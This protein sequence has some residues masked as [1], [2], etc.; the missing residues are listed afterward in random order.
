MFRTLWYTTGQM[1]RENFRWVGVLERREFGREGKGM[2]LAFTQLDDYVLRIP[3]FG[4]E[5]FWNGGGYVVDKRVLFFFLRWDRGS[6]V[7]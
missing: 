5:E 1:A 7:V 3:R 4:C 2:R 6:S